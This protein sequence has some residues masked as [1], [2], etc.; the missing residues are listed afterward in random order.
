MTNEKI[1]KHKC[2]PKCGQPMLY[3]ELEGKWRYYCKTCDKKK[4]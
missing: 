3:G 2:C 1:T 4:V